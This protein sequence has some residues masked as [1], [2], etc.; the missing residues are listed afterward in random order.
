LILDE[1]DVDHLNLK[2]KDQ[3]ECR[4]FIDFNIDNFSLY[5][6]H[7]LLKSFKYFKKSEEKVD[8]NIYT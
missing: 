2:L 6:Q 3:E 5:N 7:E 1:S 8:P 4:K